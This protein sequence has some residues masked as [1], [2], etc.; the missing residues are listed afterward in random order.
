[1]TTFRMGKMADMRL[2]IGKW[3]NGSVMLLS[4]SADWKPEELTRLESHEID[5]SSAL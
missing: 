1:M 3:W 5:R 2:P 4:W